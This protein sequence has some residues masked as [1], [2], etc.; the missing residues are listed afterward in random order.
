MRP[1][2][3]MG[4]TTGIMTPRRRWINF[5]LLIIVFSKDLFVREQDSSSSSLAAR[6]STMQ[7]LQAGNY[8]LPGLQ[9][10]DAADGGRGGGNRGNTGNLVLHGGAPDRLFVKAGFD[11]ERRVDDQIDVS[12]LDQ[13]DDIRPSLVHLEDRLDLQACGLQRPDRGLPARSSPGSG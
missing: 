11:T 8:Q 4:V 10:L 6:T 13:I 12:V 2:A 5:C 7:V 3:S 1:P 9:R